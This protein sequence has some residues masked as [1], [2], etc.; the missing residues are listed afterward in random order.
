MR[1]KAIYGRLCRNFGRK[2]RSLVSG[3]GI[4]LMLGI[5]KDSSRI[6]RKFGAGPFSAIL[7]ALGLATFSPARTGLFLGAHEA[8]SQGGHPSWI[9]PASNSLNFGV[10]TNPK[11]VSSQKALPRHITPLRLV[12]V[13]SHNLPPLR[14]R[15]PRRHTRTTRQS[16]SDTKLSHPGPAPP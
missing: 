9:A 15:R 6:W 2:S 3:P 13:G 7:S 5:P 12:D 4:G 14:I 11:P 10:L 16:G 1:P 8:T